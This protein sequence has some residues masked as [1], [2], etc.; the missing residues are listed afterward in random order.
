MR[1]THRCS[2]AVTSGSL[3]FVAHVFL[4]RR[5]Y[6]LS[7]SILYAVLLMLPVLLAFVGAI[8]AA[9]LAGTGGSTA[10]GFSARLSKSFE[11]ALGTFSPGVSSVSHDLAVCFCR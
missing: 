5:V 11:C 10:S 9:V 2:L 4:L 3:G 1:S 7:K 6:L 8:M